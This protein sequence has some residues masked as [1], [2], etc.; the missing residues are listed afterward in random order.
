MPSSSSAEP[1][2]VFPMQTTATSPP[3]VQITVSPELRPP[4]NASELLCL[5]RR[6]FAQSHEDHRKHERGSWLERFDWF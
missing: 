3:A 2:V 6:R 5:V 4:P 1:L